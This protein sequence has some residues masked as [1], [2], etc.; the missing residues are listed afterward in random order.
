VGPESF[1]NTAAANDY[2]PEYFVVGQGLIDDNQLAQL[3]N[4][5]EWSHALGVS[6]LWTMVP[7]D[8]SDATKAWQDVGNSGTPP[9]DQALYIYPYLFLGTA[10]MQAGPS[11]TP[12]GIHD[13]LV[14]LGNN[15][16]WTKLHDPTVAQW[17]L[18]QQ[19]PWTFEED[20]REVY[21]SPSRTAE[22]NG[23]PGSYCPVAGGQRYGPGEFTTDDSGL[24][25]TSGC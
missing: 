11:P 3:Y 7:F 12:W 17:G 6:S 15:G 16:G 18:D 9:P 23:K 2:Y 19:S 8:Q 25:A 5:A 21:W 14:A 10:F 20:V 13:G 4:Q 1:T 24:F 22:D